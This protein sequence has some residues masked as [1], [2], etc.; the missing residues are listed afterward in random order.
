MGWTSEPGALV[1]RARRA[2]RSL[3]WCGGHPTLRCGL[4]ARGSGCASRFSDAQCCLLHWCS[5]WSPWSTFPWWSHAL[6]AGRLWCPSYLRALF[7]LLTALPLSLLCARSR[8][9]RCH[10][11]GFFL[12]GAHR[13][14]DDDD[15]TPAPFATSS[16]VRARST[17]P[18]AMQHKGKSATRTR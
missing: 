4:G 14:D 9:S 18:A 17:W 5:R 10:G 12:Q 16:P 6:F 11:A 8:G 15:T 3:L 13:L 2:T 1:L 7:S